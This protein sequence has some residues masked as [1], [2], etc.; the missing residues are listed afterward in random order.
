M[1]DFKSFKEHERFQAVSYLEQ[2]ETHSIKMIERFGFSTKEE[3]EE[4]LK[5]MKNNFWK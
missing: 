2:D 1:K 3:A 5:E 4:K